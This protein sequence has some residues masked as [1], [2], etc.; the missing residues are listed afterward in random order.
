LGREHIYQ[1]I[2]KDITKNKK[3]KEKGIKD[4]QHTTKINKTQSKISREEK[5]K[6]FFKMV[7]TGK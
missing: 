4:C 5:T 7:T 2:I 1:F 3:D 6:G